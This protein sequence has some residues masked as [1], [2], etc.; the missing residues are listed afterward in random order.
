MR[1]FFMNKVK[2]AMLVMYS[3]CKL[4]VIICSAEEN[5]TSHKEHKYPSLIKK[6]IFAAVLSC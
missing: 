6:T 5:I 2:A 3:S 4:K 1:G